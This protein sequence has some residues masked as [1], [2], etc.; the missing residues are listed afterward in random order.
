MQKPKFTL[1]PVLDMRQARVE[2]VEIELGRLVQEQIQLQKQLQMLYDL[3]FQLMQR[4]AEGIS[5]EIDLFLCNRI[6]SDQ[7][8]VQE[9][10]RNTSQAL[11]AASQA[12]EAK[13]HELIQA[14]QS[15]E[16]MQVLK[17]KQADQFLSDQLAAEARQQDD[18]YIA[19]AYRQR[20]A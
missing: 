9:Q 4:L 17:R 3:Q 8:R 20:A 2:K 16:A 14:K 18:I 7:Q 19:Q 6:R 12:V 1:Q 15:E 10:I 5:G 13:R 11:T